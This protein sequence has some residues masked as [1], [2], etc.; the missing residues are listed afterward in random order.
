MSVSGIA[1]SIFQFLNP[2]SAQSNFQNFQKEFAQLGQDLQSGNL[3]QA[4][5]DF[6]ALQS[7]AQPVS[8]TNT[9]SSTSSLSSAMSQLS[10]D[11]QSGNLSAAQQDY[12]TVKQDLQQQFS[13]SVSGHHH[14][15]HHAS[16]SQDSSSQDPFSQL[17][18]QLGQALQSGNLSAAQSAYTSLQQDLQQLGAPAPAS[19]S[20]SSSPST[21]SVNLSA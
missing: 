4:Q 13:G 8:S 18:S 16:S 20:S 6:Q 12:A 5:S 21:N 17:F 19:T 15:H 3:S 9:Q 2:S 10:Q 1:N 7:P 11:L 14:H